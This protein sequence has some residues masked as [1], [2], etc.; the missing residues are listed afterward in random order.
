MILSHIECEKMFVLINEKIVFTDQN[1]DVG[2]NQ[3]DST[4]NLDD[5]S[6]LSDDASGAREET[7]GEPKDGRLLLKIMNVFFSLICKMFNIIF[8]F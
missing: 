3:N 6:F 1:T 7:S 2:I 8:T 5:E 4:E